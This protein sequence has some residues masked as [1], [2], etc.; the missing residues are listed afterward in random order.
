MYNVV[1]FLKAS[2]TAEETPEIK[3]KGGAAYVGDDGKR[4]VI[5]Q[6]SYLGEKSTEY[7]TKGSVRSLSI[8]FLPI[9]KTSKY[10]IVVLPYII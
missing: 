8:F 3:G 5:S 10:Y 4:T 9:I 6:E 2:D 1:N 7:G